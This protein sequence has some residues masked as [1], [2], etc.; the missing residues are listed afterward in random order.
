MKNK[1]HPNKIEANFAYF[2][3]F[4]S[5]SPLQMFSHRI[6]KIESRVEYIEIV[7]HFGLFVL[8]KQ[9]RIVAQITVLVVLTFLLTSH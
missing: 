1:N 6:E 4:I 9:P 8:G 3:F 5:F 2:D 7:V